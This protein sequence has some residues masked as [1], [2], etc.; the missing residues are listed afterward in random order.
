[1]AVFALGTDTG[2][3]GGGNSLGVRV[4]NA[5]GC[6][7]VEQRWWCVWLLWVVHCRWLLWA[8]RGEQCLWL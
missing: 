7:R 3:G 4:G 1:M 2:M 5:L 6:M 8:L